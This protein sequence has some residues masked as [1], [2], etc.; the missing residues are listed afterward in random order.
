MAEKETKEDSID[1]KEAIKSAMAE[2]KLE[3]AEKEAS[4]IDVKELVREM[5]AEKDVEVKEVKSAVAPI[6]KDVS[7]T[8]KDVPCG[9]FKSKAQAES[10]AVEYVPEDVLRK[11]GNKAALST[12]QNIATDADGGSFDPIDAKGLLAD[13]TE[14]YPSYIADTLQVKIFNSVGTFIDHTGDATT[15]VIGEGVAATQSKPENTTRTLTQ[16]KL[17]TLCPVTNEVF[18]FGTLVDVAQATLASMR[19]ATSK[20]KQHL[21]FTAD[22]TVDTIDGSVKGIITSITD[23]ASNAGIYEVAGNWGTIDNEDISAIATSLPMWSNPSKYAWY[24]HQNMWGSLEQI[25]RELGGNQYLVQTGQRPQPMLFGYPI[26]FVNQMPSSF[27]EDEIGMLFGD[28]SSMVATGSDGNTYVDSSDG[29]WFDQDTT[30]LRLIE[31]LA[32]NVY[33]PGTS[34]VVPAMR[35]IKFSAVS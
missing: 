2:I 33:Q 19:N 31:N 1:V 7:I 24:C 12:Y 22:G 28:A 16:K 17:V 8:V 35:A 30:A 13:S 20:K 32:V 3:Q 6:V 27:V 10:W 5:L 25:A 26:K 29:Q 11:F 15:H 34:S 14:T 23:V 21:I 4:E 18:R 9:D